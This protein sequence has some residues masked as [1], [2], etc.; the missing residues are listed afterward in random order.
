MKAI[1]VYSMGLAF[2][3]MHRIWTLL[4]QYSNNDHTLYVVRE[5]RQ[6]LFNMLYKS[7]DKLHDKAVTLEILAEIM[8]PIHDNLYKNSDSEERIHIK[9]D[10]NELL[11]KISATLD[12]L[13]YILQQ[14]LVHEERTSLIALLKEY[15]EFEI[16]IWKLI[17][18][19]HNP[20]FIEKIFVIRTRNQTISLFGGTIAS[21]KTML[22]GNR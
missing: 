14:T 19:T 21:S 18:M 16:T 5:A 10:D 4:I 1:T 17:D 8:K 11:H 22:Q 2:L 6:V 3:R 20:Y 9:V 12:L 15:H 13:S 7:C